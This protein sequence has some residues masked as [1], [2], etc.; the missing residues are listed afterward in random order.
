MSLPEPIERSKLNQSMY[1]KLKKYIMN[2]RKQLVERTFY[3][4][5]INAVQI[6]F[7]IVSDIF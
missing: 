2:K 7:K 4:D 5:I 3:F 6:Y 1:K